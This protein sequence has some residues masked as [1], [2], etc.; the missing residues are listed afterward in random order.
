M[1]PAAVGFQCPS[2]VSQ[3]RT[4]VRTPRSLFGAA[5]KPGG[6]T[7]T[8]VLMG[9]VGGLWLLNLITL[10]LVASATVLS[11]QAVAAGQFWRL[12]TYGFISADL[13]GTLL[14]VL[15][16]WLVGRALE[17]EMG[18]WRFVGLY[19]VAGLGG[20]TLCFLLGPPGLVGWGAS[21]SIIGLLAAN[22]I[23]KY[24]NREDIR[25]DIGLLVLLIL[26]SVLVG[27]SGFGWLGMI[28]GALAGALTGYLLAYAP[29]RNRT[30]VQVVGMLSIAA[31][32]LIA[33]VAKIVLV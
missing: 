11:N 6:G 26:Y 32:C 5:M 24:R 10:G 15:V 25:G 31:L 7:A 20:A 12:L 17:G 14:N 9:V 13:L 16:L 29:R 18:A 19:A 3:G 4:S 1:T 33:V 27:F 2:C 22:T 21:S 23:G 28:G 30:P 8:K